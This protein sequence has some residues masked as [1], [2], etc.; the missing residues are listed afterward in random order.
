MIKDKLSGKLETPKTNMLGNNKNS[1][2]P[3]VGNDYGDGVFVVSAIPFI[4]ELKDIHILFLLLSIMLTFYIYNLYLN[5]NDENMIAHL[6]ESID[7]LILTNFIINI[8]LMIYCSLIYGI[9]TYIYEFPK[10]D[11]FNLIL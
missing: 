1:G 2:S 7:I 10:Y 5:Q 4:N 11:M 6:K 9:Y 8:F 3:K